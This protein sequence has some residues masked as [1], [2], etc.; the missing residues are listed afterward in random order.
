MD[1]LKRARSKMMGI[2]P[3]ENDEGLSPKP[4]KTVRQRGT[5][6]ITSPAPGKKPMSD[7]Q[8]AFLHAKG[9]QFGK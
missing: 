7:K 2:D 6:Q 4:L 5:G 1:F 3:D 8:R 9:K